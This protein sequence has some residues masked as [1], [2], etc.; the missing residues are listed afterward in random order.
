ME[1]LEKG[2]IYTAVIDGRQRLL[3]CAGLFSG[4]AGLAVR[5]IHQLRLLITS[6]T[7][8]ASFSVFPGR[9]FQAAFPQPCFFIQKTENLS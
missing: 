7:G 4:R 9:F 2:S 6:K 8:E 1:A 3:G 5:R